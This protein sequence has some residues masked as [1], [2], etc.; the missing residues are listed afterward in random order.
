MNKKYIIIVLV[1]MASLN[2]VFAQEQFNLRDRAKKFL[3]E[4]KYFQA[5]NIYQKLVDIKSPK[6]EDMED[7]AFCYVKMQDYEAAETWYA[8]IVAVKGSKPENL[9]KYG[10]A[11]KSNLKY[12]EAKKTLQSYVSLT[13]KSDTVSLSIA[14]CDSAMVWLA[15]PTI[16]KIK[17][18]GGINTSLA[19]F[20]AFPY[21]SGVFFVSE[22]DV[23]SKMFMVVL[24]ALICVFT[25][26]RKAA[27][28]YSVQL[29]LTLQFTTKANTILVQLQLIRLVMFCM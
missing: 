25:K 20:G 21:K 7:L 22:P 13:G 24:V 12:V 6:V 9:I 27:I 3:L 11:L 23:K 28:T 26:Q 18:E 5:A 2:S 15:N 17:N 10:E 29:K 19:N 8:R 16:H 1:A 4:Y 14:G